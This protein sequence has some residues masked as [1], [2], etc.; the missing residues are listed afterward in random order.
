MAEMGKQNMTI[1]KHSN[2]R[3][4]VEP[5]IRLLAKIKINES[6]GCFEWQ[7]ALNKGYAWFSNGEKACN[8]Y[9]WFYEYVF[10]KVKNG[11]QLDH[12]CR[13]RACV[14]P[15]HLEEVTSRENN[16]RGNGFAA[17]RSRQTHCLRGH[18]FNR[19]NTYLTPN[20]QRRCLKCHAFRERRRRNK[21]FNIEEFYANT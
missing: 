15:A 13:N 20:N 3:K 21:K 17:I 7:G 9:K 4:I 8:A 2:N 6:S 19:D 5:I 12:L 16:L 11:L 18:L 1:R 14:N 10:G